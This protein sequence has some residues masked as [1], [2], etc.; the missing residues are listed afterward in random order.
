M[1]HIDDL[2]LIHVVAVVEMCVGRNQD[3]RFFCQCTK[4]GQDS[5]TLGHSRIDY[6]RSHL[7]FNKVKRMAILIQNASYLC[8]DPLNVIFVH[9]FLLVVNTCRAN[10]FIT[11][12]DA[13]ISYSILFQIFTV[14]VTIREKGFHGDTVMGRRDSSSSSRR[15]ILPLM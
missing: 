14:P 8:L 5:N 10:T 4:H 13:V 15:S 11:C 3:Q 12:M 6:C 1:A 7:S 9:C 2:K